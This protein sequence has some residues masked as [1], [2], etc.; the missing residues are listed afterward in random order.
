MSLI[1]QLA[2]AEALADRLRRQIAAAKCT[3]VGHRWKHI[4]GKN[5]GC[6][7]VDADGSKWHGSCSV[8]V[9]ECEVC[10]DC[11]YGDNQEAR[12]HKTACAAVDHDQEWL[13]ELSAEAR[14]Q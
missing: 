3:E 5:C 4:G 2:E 13:S 9:Y 11:D 8:P 7:G 1:D 12:D 6:E 14:G 10:K